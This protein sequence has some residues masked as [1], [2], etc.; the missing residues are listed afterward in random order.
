[1]SL[2]LFNQFHLSNEL[3]QRLGDVIANAAEHGDVGVLDFV[4]RAVKYSV[5]GKLRDRDV[6]TLQTL[7]RTY[8]RDYYRH[9]VHVEQHGDRFLLV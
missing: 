3:V 2:N 7:E 8:N 6:N 9:R 4:N 1:M 5:N